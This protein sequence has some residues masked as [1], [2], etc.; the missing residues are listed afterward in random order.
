[1]Q[2][3]GMRVLDDERVEIVQPFAEEHRDDIGLDDRRIVRP[4][5]NLD[6]VGGER[7]AELQRVAARHDEL[8]ELDDDGDPLRLGRAAAA[9]A[10]RFSVRSR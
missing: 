1:M 5:Q 3:R 2:S 9:S 6:D 7:A 4:A 8:R 10:C